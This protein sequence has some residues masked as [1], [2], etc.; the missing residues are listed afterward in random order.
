MST[1]KSRTVA[2]LREELAANRAKLVSDVSDFVSEV[3][4]KNMAKRSLENAKGFVSE[5]FRTVKRQVQDENG[6]RV[7]RLTVIGGAV[8]GIVVF[9]VTINAVANRRT[10]R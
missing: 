8:L 2:E 6:W 4:P 1:N 7:D 5:E 10:A 9:A 3:H